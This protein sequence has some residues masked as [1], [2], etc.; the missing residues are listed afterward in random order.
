MQCNGKYSVMGYLLG[1]KWSCCHWLDKQSVYTLCRATRCSFRC[2]GNTDCKL[3]F[4][5]VKL[6]VSAMRSRLLLMNGIGW[7]KRCILHL[8]VFSLWKWMNCQ[9]SCRFSSYGSFQ[10][11]KNV[12]WSTF[13]WQLSY[14]KVLHKQQVFESL[15]SDGLTFLWCKWKTSRCDQAKPKC[16]I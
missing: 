14:F 16:G 5:N 1:D 2:A 8:V 4:K 11:H 10:L 13:K 7:K 6:S 12:N 3:L 9:I 15:F